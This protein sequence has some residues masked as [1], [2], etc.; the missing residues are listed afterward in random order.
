MPR[1]HGGVFALARNEDASVAFKG[2]FK[3]VKK[4]LPTLRYARLAANLGSVETIAG[5]GPQPV[6][7]SPQQ[8]SGGPPGLPRR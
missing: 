1:S 3:A 4:F 5:Q 2:D 6:T 7:L 8:R